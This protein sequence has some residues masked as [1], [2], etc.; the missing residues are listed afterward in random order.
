MDRIE[1]SDIKRGE[2]YYIH[3]KPVVG[4]E[5]YAGRP[6]IVVSNDTNNAHSSTIEVV[7]MTTREKAE[8]PT[9]VYLVSAPKVSIALCEQIH[10]VSVDRVGNYIGHVTRDEMADIERAILISLGLKEEDAERRSDDAVPK[11]FMNQ[12]LKAV[13][14]RDTYKTLYEDLLDRI[15]K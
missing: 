1:R 11:D 8:L 10:T 2:I 5:Q 14:E 15:M 12:Y 9:H 3:K 7:L 13:A 6:G 4:S